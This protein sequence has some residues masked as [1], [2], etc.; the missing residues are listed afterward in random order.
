M[1]MLF[2]YVFQKLQYELSKYCSNIVFDF[3]W[4]YNESPCFVGKK[5]EHFDAEF[6]YIVIYD[7]IH[8]KY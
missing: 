4:Q 8:N 1:L 6:S 3:E 7:G 5:H 2:I